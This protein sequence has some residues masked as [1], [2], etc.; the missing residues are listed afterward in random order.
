MVKHLDFHKIELVERIGALLLVC[1][2]DKQGNMYDWAPKWNDVEELYIKQTNIERFNKPESKWL[3]KFAKTAQKV[4][5]GAQRLESAYKVSGRFVKYVD[6]QLMIESGG[7]NVPSFI[8]PGFEIT[9]TFLDSWLE[10]YVD[11]FV[12]NDMAIRIRRFFVDENNEECYREY[13][14]PEDEELKPDDL[15]F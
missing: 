4:V 13:P 15:P 5:E 1:F 6:G 2:L 8:T 11:L 7:R 10:H 3:N 9:V 14:E 12:I